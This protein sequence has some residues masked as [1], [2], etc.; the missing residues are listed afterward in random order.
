MLVVRRRRAG[1]LFGEGEQLLASFTTNE[2]LTA[3]ISNVEDAV[4][5]EA[6]DPV[7]LT[8]V[9][10][11]VTVEIQGPRDATLVFECHQASGEITDVRCV[12][13]LVS[14]LGLHGLGLYSCPSP[15]RLLTSSHIARSHIANSRIAEEGLGALADGENHLASCGSAHRRIR[16]FVGDVYRTVAQVVYSLTSHLFG[17]CQ[18]FDR[19]VCAR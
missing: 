19:K 13:H 12:A 17:R 11:S 16:L 6:R 3:T 8:P 2:D 18:P 7:L 5:C 4:L 15:I 1:V 14:P 10:K 9:V